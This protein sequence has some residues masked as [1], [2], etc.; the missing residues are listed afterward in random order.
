M[1]L[2][3]T[4]VLAGAAMACALVVLWPRPT[5]AEEISDDE[6]R[7]DYDENGGPMFDGVAVT[8]TLAPDAKVP[9]GWVLVRT[10][11]NTK[12]EPATVSV[13][14]RIM[15]EESQLEARVSGTSLVA[16]ATTRSFSLGPHE[17]RK[18]GIALPAALG[19]AITAGDRTHAA[20]E[21]AREH[22]GDPGARGRVA[23]AA[24]DRTY[25]IYFVQ[26]LKPLPP[27]ATAKAPD[28]VT[29]PGRMPA[30]PSLDVEPAFDPAPSASA[31]ASAS[32]SASAPP[33]VAASARRGTK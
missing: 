9:G 1:R 10:I 12:D 24:F 28:Y 7:P 33:I 4:A 22:L 17:T 30:A 25:R 3:E 8:A 2:R 32:P 14:E 27:G 13:D 21:R 6:R 29:G 31:A 26:Y 15:R 5:C 20:A 23:R 18:V 11:V 19:E 16:S